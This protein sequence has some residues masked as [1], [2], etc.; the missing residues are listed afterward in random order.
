MLKLSY[1][2]NAICLL[3]MVLVLPIVV[4]LMTGDFVMALVLIFVA[5][6]SDG[7]DGFIAK[8]FD[9]R[10]RLGGILD[11]LADKL[12]LVSVFITL[13][14]LQLTPVWLAAIVIGRDL[15]IV[16]G[17]TAYNFL[18]GRVQPEPML[19]SKVNTALQLLYILV[20]IAGGAF[21]WPG[22]IVIIIV[23]ASV[24]VSSVV[25]GLSYVLRWGGKAL[26]A[27]AV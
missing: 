15:V 16:A 17:A 4:S 21:S 22:H 25:S 11:P 2:P 8:R 7:V 19:I 12:L 26:A 10:T 1:I 23:G 27:K 20:V 9:W 14:V 18:I 5:G 24:M 6:F 13:T 3:R